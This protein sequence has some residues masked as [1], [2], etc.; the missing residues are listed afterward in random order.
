MKNRI[1]E[2]LHVRHRSLRTFPGMLLLGPTG[3]RL[4][5][6]ALEPAP[7]FWG[8]LDFIHKMNLP[9]LFTVTAEGMPCKLEPMEA[10]WYPDELVQRFENTD[11]R[12]YERKLITWEDVAVS[13]QRWEN[14]GA[15]ALRLTLR[16]PEGMRTGRAYTFPEDAHGVRPV[17]L[18][19]STIRWEDGG[20]CLAPGACVEFLLAEA[21]GT[22]EEDVLE[23][24]LARVLHADKA[25][26]EVMDALCEAYL[27]WF[28][29]VPAFSC[30][31]P[32]TE[33]CWWYRYYILRNSLARPALGNLQGYVFYEGRSHRM[34]KAP[35][36]PGGWEFSRLIPLSTPL[37]MADAQWLHGMGDV[38]GDGFRSL[39]ASINEDGV[40]SVTSVDSRSKVT[41]ASCGSSKGQT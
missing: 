26:E 6:D 23:A 38:L 9:L 19:D 27:R 15:D 34:K 5:A 2:M 14:T 31:D 18:L 4:W 33:R 22:A 28:D 41:V 32:L 35:A 1:K 39:V 30:D 25:P 13:Y 29:H 12:F 3:A 36:K 40:F 11:V 17:A 16:V 24:R 37:T 7:G 10:D 21:V 20:L 8:N